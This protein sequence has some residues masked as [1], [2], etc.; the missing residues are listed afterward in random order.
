MEEEKW[1]TDE[2]G[3]KYRE[4]TWMKWVFVWEYWFKPK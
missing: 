4:I 3:K 1:L 2:N